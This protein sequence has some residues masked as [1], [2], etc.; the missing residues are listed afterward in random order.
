MVALLRIDHRRA[1]VEGRRQV[2]KLLQQQVKVTDSGLNWVV[3]TEVVRSRQ[4]LDVLFRLI[5]WDLL[6]MY[7]MR[8][9]LK[10]TPSFQP[11]LQESSPLLFR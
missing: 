1:R 6:I 8:E 3:A 9:E 2:R 11:E 10:T 5:Q 4:H 7:S